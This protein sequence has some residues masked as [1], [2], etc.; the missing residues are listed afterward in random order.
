M[1]HVNI[2]SILL[3]RTA[4]PKCTKMGRDKSRD[5]LAVYSDG[6]IHCF[7]CGYHGSDNPL[8][9]LHTT[10]LAPIR[11]GINLPADVTTEYPDVCIKWMEKYNITKSYMIR[12]GIVWSEEGIKFKDKQARELLIF[13]SWSED[14]LLFFQGRNF[15]QDKTIPKWI[16]RGKSDKVFHFLYNG[17]PDSKIRNTL[18]FTEDIISAIKVSMVGVSTMPLFGNNFKNRIEHIKKLTTMHHKLL[19]WLDPDMTIHSAKECSIARLRGLQVYSIHSKYDP[20]EHSL[21]EIEN[22][23]KENTPQFQ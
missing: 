13:P 16:G 18:V 5:N 9:S 19:L 22:Y 2:H 8:R 17:V 10:E 15:S 11:R 20:K 14:E 23:V 3:Y 1:Q 6:H 12:N 4:C 7:S 21:R